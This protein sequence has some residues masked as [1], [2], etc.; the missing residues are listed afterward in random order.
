MAEGSQ[1]LNEPPWPQE[2]ISDEDTL[3]LRVHRSY[4]RDGGATIP[5]GVFK[6]KPTDNDGMSTNW[7][8]Y[9]SEL[10]ARERARNPIDNGVV[11]AT[12][13][14]VRSV[15]SQIVRHTPIQR[16]GA[17]SPDR[18]HTDVFG[19]KTTEVRAKLSK[20]FQWRVRLEQT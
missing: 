19:P 13:R 15:P 14:E 7:S 3:F 9:C 4:M 6:N 5:P 11:A 18:S 12:V 8:K 17:A 2:D 1:Q 16:G 10:E 20:T